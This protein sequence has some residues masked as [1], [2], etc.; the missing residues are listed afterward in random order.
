VGW[1]WHLIFEVATFIVVCIATVLIWIEGTARRRERG[2]VFRPEPRWR[3][4]DGPV[5]GILR[6]EVSNL[7]GAALGCCVLMQ[8][9]DAL[10]AGNCALAEQQS[11]NDAT[12]RLMDTLDIKSPVPSSVLCVACDLAGH[13]TVWGPSTLIEGLTAHELPFA[14][15]RLLR[16]STDH[17]YSCS[18]T[19]NGQVTILPLPTAPA[20]VT[21]R[22]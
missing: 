9:D 5:D 15:A 18:I 1:D 19:A 3:I 2:L 13:W 16:R 22:A 17:Q 12:L 10:Y 21:A 7:G 11:W 6:V 14:V 8:V 20:S 4:V